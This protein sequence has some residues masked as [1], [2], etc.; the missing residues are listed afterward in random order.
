MSLVFKPSPSPDNEDVS[1][2][3]QRIDVPS[4]GDFEVHIRRPTFE[5]LVADSDRYSGVAR[6]RLEKHVIGWRGLKQ[7]IKRTDLPAGTPEEDCWQEQDLPFSFSHLQQLC[8]A[9]PVVYMQIAGTVNRTY[10]GLGDPEKG[11]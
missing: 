2:F 7:K 8:T 9:Y 11:N 3:W 5:D 1:T 10:R 6:H 4:V